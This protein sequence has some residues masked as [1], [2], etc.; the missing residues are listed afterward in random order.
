MSDKWTSSFVLG[1]L[2]MGGLCFAQQTNI[3]HFEREFIPV[4]YTSG[5]PTVFKIIAGAREL[6]GIVGPTNISIIPDQTKATEYEAVGLGYDSPEEAWTSVMDYFPQSFQIHSNATY[7]NAGFIKVTH[8]VYGD[9]GAFLW[10]LQNTIAFTSSASS[11]YASSDGATSA[12]ASVLVGT[13]GDFCP[14]TVVTDVGPAY[15]TNYLGAGISTDYV[16]RADLNAYYKL[17]PFSSLGVNDADSD[18]DDI[19]DFAD[20]YNRD[21]QAANP[22]DLSTNDFFTPWP[23]LL[24]GYADPTQALISITYSNS[25]PAGVTT[26]TNGYAP[27]SGYFRLW[28]TQA[29]HARNGASILSGGDYIPS[30]TYAATS[31]GFSVS[32]QLVDLFIEPVAPATNQTLVVEV[33]PDGSGPK[34]FV[35]MDRWQS[36]VIRIVGLDWR[37]ST[38]EAMHHTALYQ[39]NALVL[40]RCD[41]FMVDVH[42]SA[43][44]SSCEH[45]LWFEAFDTFDGSLK[46]SEVPVVT[47][48]LSPGE[49]YAILLTMSNNADGTR[50]ASVEINIPT[51]CPVGEYQWRVCLGQNEQNRIVLAQKW[52][53]DYVIILFNPWSVHDAVYIANDTDREEY[54]LR[55]AG[56]MWQ[57]FYYAKIS[58]A[59]RYAQFNAE[60]LKVFLAELC[61]LGSAARSSPIQLSQRLAVAVRDNDAGI[62]EGKWAPPYSGGTAPSVWSG[63]DE[64]LDQYASS[65]TTVKYAQ[66]WVFGGV[67]TSLLRCSGIPARPITNYESADDNDGNKIIQYRWRKIGNVWTNTGV[68]NQWNFHVWCDAWMNRPDRPGDAGWQAVDGTYA[69]GPAP[70]SAV[71][72]DS[73]GS[74]DVDFVWAEISADEE[75]YTWQGG[76]WVLQRTIPNP[77]GV[78]ISTKSVGTDARQNITDN[79]K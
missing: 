40:R 36:T 49:W 56:I 45:K 38:N 58:T 37:A 44:F 55:T 70:L 33:D 51:N 73:G 13:I 4:A 64:I 60:T 18:G 7:E 35:C 78:E 6:T 2:L 5:S 24:S 62:M 53:Q 75:E 15:D 48:D 32:T 46:T 72:A 29:A 42:L 66:C 26:G 74:Y 69:I 41:K 61:G 1:W 19:P 17:V 25:D 31:L 16:A 50:T 8:E 21:G 54:V 43:G 3:Y 9:W 63:S 28:R 22:D 65:G 27:A 77:Y 57:G 23:V 67:L 30:A 59:W 10:Y 34:E 79:Y 11:A 52:F 47:S 76:A 68:D 12:I 20:G 71:K 14:Q 39:T